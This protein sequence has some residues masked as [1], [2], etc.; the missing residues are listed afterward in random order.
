MTT[1]GAGVQ[2]RRRLSVSTEKVFAAFADAALVA[3]SLAARAMLGAGLRPAGRRG[4]VA[5]WR[6]RAGGGRGEVGSVIALARELQARREARAGLVEQRR[7]GEARAADV[8]HGLTNRGDEIPELTDEDLA[9]AMPARLR[10]R[11]VRG[12]FESGSDIAALRRF[13]RLS[14]T[15]FAKAMGIVRELRFISAP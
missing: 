10:R 15:Q 12:Q 1:G 13:V 11:L 8:E 2:I 9:S 7:L 3:Q 14:Q 6:A 4:G 5:S